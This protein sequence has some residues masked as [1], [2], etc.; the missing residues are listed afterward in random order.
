MIPDYQT[1][2][3]PLLRVAGDGQ[4]RAVKEGYLTG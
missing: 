3:V 1:L 4:V 2:K